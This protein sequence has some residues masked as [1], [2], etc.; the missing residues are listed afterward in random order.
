MDKISRA[1]LL[2]ALRRCRPALAKAGNRA[3]E[4]TTFWFD[5]GS[6]SA[7]NGRLAIF[8]DLPTELQG[9]VEHT[10]F[11]WLLDTEGETAVLSV[12]AGRIVGRSGEGN[13]NG[14]GAQSI[15]PSRLTVTV[16]ASEA[17]FAILPKDR[18]PLKPEQIEQMLPPVKSGVKIDAEFSAGLEN[19]LV[20]LDPMSAVLPR[21]GAFFVPGR[22]NLDVY[23]TDDVTISW[24]H[25]PLPAGFATD[26]P[27][28]LMPTGFI[29]QLVN[30]AQ[31]SRLVAVD[32]EEPEEVPARRALVDDEPELPLAEPEDVQLF[33]HGRSALAMSPGILAIGHLIDHQTMP[34]F[35][36]ELD[37]YA[38]VKTVAVPADLR[39]AL[40]RVMLLKSPAG[41]F[42]VRD[43]TLLIAT[44]R[45]HGALWESL[46]LPGHP[47]I[48][49]HYS[50]ELVLRALSGRTA[51][52]ISDSA[53]CLSGPADFLH[54]IAASVS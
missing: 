3:V 52:R 11:R 14:E 38:A 4:L 46:P 18:Q 53:I 7:Y 41:K 19:I 6:V 16:G 10:L 2:D 23:A 54:L 34:D 5:G 35:A 40:R 24:L 22:D 44:E 39:A 47:D 51:L 21:M 25:L 26:T 50:P 36:G 20:S 32:R 12:E 15:E 45:S 29:R 1:A 42:T 28:I 37:S 33:I 9:G 48:E 30:M 8:A 27:F 31:P 49:A 17:R 13:Q 43:E